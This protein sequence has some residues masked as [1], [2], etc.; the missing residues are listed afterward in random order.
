MS[1]FKFKPNK[2]VGGVSNKTRV[3]RAKQSL[4]AC[5]EY[6][7]GDEDCVCDLIADL[8]HY[9]DSSGSEDPK[10]ELAVAVRHWEEER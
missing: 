9:L 10:E 7:N 4:A 6:C 5:Q 3:L 8:L 2:K 1:K